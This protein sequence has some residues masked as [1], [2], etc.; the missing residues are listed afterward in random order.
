MILT[1][2]PRW[3]SRTPDAET[4]TTPGISGAPRDME[5]WRT[6]VR[7][8][9]TRY[10]GRIHEYE[11]WNEPNRLKSW[12]GDVDTLVD[13]TEEAAK[14][15]KEV[16][17][18]NLVISPPPTGPSGVAFLREFLSKGGG[19]HV[20]IIGYHF[21]VPRT[22]SPEA[23]VPLIQQV[24]ATMI[25]FGVDHK[26]LWDTEAGWLGPD[27]FP[28]DQQSAYVAR[29]FILNW[30]AGVDR[31]YWYAWESHRGSQI[32][33]TGSNNTTLTP[34]G[35]A[36]ATIQQWLMGSV[37]KSCVT[38]DNHNW[39]CQMDRNGKTEYIVWNSL[40]QASFRIS[41]DWHVSQ[42]TQLNGSVNSIRSDS[43]PI[44]GQPVLLQ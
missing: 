32:E 33:L 21:Y 30:A 29:A 43:I 39:F 20:D 37:M 41:S 7:T 1:F 26:P 4:D 24:R 2:S 17:T 34:A 18:H 38:S 12:T 36:F 15:L 31:F 13:M 40:G 42:I 19:K 9:A 5:D 3:A 44:N 11:I 8:V 6:F 16:D 14:I 23:M 10:R 27:F 22:D 35:T 25:Q 28:D